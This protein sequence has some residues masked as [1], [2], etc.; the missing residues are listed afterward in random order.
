MCFTEIINKNEQSSGGIR[1]LIPIRKAL[2]NDSIQYYIAWSGINIVHDNCCRS[3]FFSFSFRRTQFFHQHRKDTIIIKNAHPLYSLGAFAWIQPARM[4]ANFELEQL[5]RTKL[6]QYNYYSSII[7]PFRFVGIFVLL[8]V[9]VYNLHIYNKLG[10]QKK[11]AVFADFF[12]LTCLS[13]YSPSV[14]ENAEQYAFSF[15]Q[16]VCLN[17]YIYT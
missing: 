7:R 9:F 17:P 1:V 13:K 5:S 3:F 10:E 16:L 6:P 12:L 15:I 4:L 2:E 8:S 11:N 14:T